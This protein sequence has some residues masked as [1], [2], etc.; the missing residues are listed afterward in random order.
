VLQTSPTS[1]PPALIADIGG[2]TS[3]FALAACGQR[4][5]QVVVVSNANFA[6]V[7]A[8]ITQYLNHVGVRPS[9]AILAVAG[10][11]NGEEVALTNRSWHFHKRD[12]AKRFDLHRLRV[13]ND[14]EAV[15]W[16]V[17]GFES[18]DTRPIGG[19]AKPDAGVKVVLGPGTGLGV[20]GLVPSCGG[21]QVV[22]SE[23]GHVSFGPGP[24]EEQRVFDWLWQEYGHVSAEMVLS[25][26]G[27][28]RLYRAVNVGQ[29]L[30]DPET[31]VAMAKAGDGPARAT[32]SLFTR[33]LARFAGGLA[34]TFKAT[35]G[36][37]IAGGVATAI[38]S[39]LDEEQF[40]RAFE[41]HPPHQA[42]LTTIPTFHITCQEP[43][44]VG[45]ATL[46]ERFADVDEID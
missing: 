26:A 15:A 35:G 16:A 6:T 30:P 5:Q 14:F 28:R 13:I 24:R 12:L 42:L 25:G 27:L 44:L 19:K 17:L 40:R 23:G 2:S 45:C 32:T 31:I 11:I 4:P 10:P 34:L 33:L 38:S 29:S 21:W 46:V 9:A 7:E 22:A 39:M 3:R 41:T 8:A 37:Y 43:G 20:A 1:R 36:V 18:A